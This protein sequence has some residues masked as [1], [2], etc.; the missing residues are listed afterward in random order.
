MTTASLVP[1]HGIARLRVVRFGLAFSLLTVLF[2]YGLG[3]AFGA[4]EDRI[5]GHLKAEGQAALEL[6][7]DGDTTKMNKTVKKS[8]TYFKRAHLHANGMGTTALVL[9]LL[10]AALDQR[11]RLR[12]ITATLLGL[13]SLGYGV[14]W[15]AAGLRAP[16]LGSTGAAKL[17]LEWLAVPAAGA[18]LIGVA[19]T[20]GLTAVALFR[21]RPAKS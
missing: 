13:G 11:E 5:K 4:Q 7:Y 19:L 21:A 1:L 16:G 12:A 15:L 17:S 3:G 10:L 9:C 14:F 6:I 18:S 8:W 2:G 20:I